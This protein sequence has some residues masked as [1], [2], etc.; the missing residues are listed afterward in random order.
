MQWTNNDC[1]FFFFT[2][3]NVPVSVAACLTVCDVSTYAYM[4]IG[5]RPCRH[6][7]VWGARILGQRRRRRRPRRNTRMNIRV[8]AS[9]FSG[10]PGLR[11]SQRTSTQQGAHRSC[12][13][14][15]YAYQTSYTHARTRTHGYDYIYVSMY[16]MWWRIDLAVGTMLLGSGSWLHREVAFLEGLAARRTQYSR[17]TTIGHLRPLTVIV[18][19]VG[20]GYRYDVAPSAEMLCHG[21]SLQMCVC[22]CCA[23]S[24]IKDRETVEENGTK[25]KNETTKSFSDRRLVSFHIYS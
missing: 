19:F 5:Q 8:G 10:S 3:I 12:M 18:S 11:E 24:C 23:Y 20:R 13:Y 14:I 15:R 4:N 21:L 2:F 25:E 17:K 16:V 22:V 7:R 6:C 1:S 9:F